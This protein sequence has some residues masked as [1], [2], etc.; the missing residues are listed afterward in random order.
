MSAKILN[1]KQ[2]LEFQIAEMKRGIEAARQERLAL[3]HD[4]S[5]RQF[6]DDNLQKAKDALQAAHSQREIIEKETK[7]T[8]EREY[9][10][11]IDALIQSKREREQLERALRDAPDAM[12]YRTLQDFNSLRSIKL[13]EMNETIDDEKDIEEDYDE[14]DDIITED[15]KREKA[16][17]ALV[18]VDLWEPAEDPSIT[19]GALQKLNTLS[20]KERNRKLIR[21][22]GAIPILIEILK[23]ADPSI[24][25]TPSQSLALA[26]LSIL[27]RNV[28]NRDEVRRQD[29]LR[30]VFRIAKVKDEKDLTEC[31]KCLRELCKN[32]SSRIIFRDGK[33]IEF[34]ISHLEKEQSAMIQ[35]LLLDILTILN[36]NDDKSQSI[37]KAANGV[38]VVLKYC[39]SVHE[40]VKRKAIRAIGYIAQNNRKIQQTIRKSSKIIPEIVKYLDDQN[41]EMKRTACTAI[42][43]ISENDYENQI[44]IRKC[45]A[46]NMLM[47]IIATDDIKEETLASAV[48]A[49]RNLAKMNLKVQSD[50]Y[51]D[52]TVIPK[53]VRLLDSENM[54]IKINAVGAIMELSRENSTN[55]DII[56]SSGAPAK[57]IACLNTENVVIQ[58]L[59]E[60][61]IWCLAKK[62]AKRRHAFREAVPV[63]QE[64]SRSDNPQ[65]QKGALWALEVL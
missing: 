36:I 53:L 17:I 6:L 22:A 26:V 58:Y 38:N 18:M 4:K 20:L 48:H 11:V 46:V 54:N 60:G 23:D 44:A 42:A 56:C 24:G 27:C 8:Y 10:S 19:E 47:K 15:D 52:N 5:T 63:L 16:K 65:I 31:L 1:E 14:E 35:E 57:L 7:S 49:I 33:L 34:I 43:C 62:N 30:H 2:I 13:S 50:F 64:L 41:D 29:G 25:L 32:D 21:I 40:D 59:A 51:D 28:R 3:S 39:N 55:S 45:G 9:R 12:N 61:T 37:T